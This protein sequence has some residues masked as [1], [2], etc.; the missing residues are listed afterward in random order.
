MPRCPGGVICPATVPQQQPPSSMPLLAC[1]N[2]AMGTPQVGFF[3]RVEPPTVL[4]IICLVSI[5]VSAFYFE[6]PD[7]MSYSPVGAQP[8]GFALLQPFGVYPWHAHVQPGDGHWSMPG[9]HRVAVPS[10]TLS[11]WEPSATQSPVPQPFHLYDGAYSLGGLVESHPIP[12]P[13][14]HGGEGSSFL[15]L[16]PSDD[17]V[18]S[19]LLYN[20]LEV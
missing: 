2:Y 18:D 4:Y 6:V 19:E 3:F 12:Q 10:A 15:G 5:L 7:W 16:V 8:L 20:T 14:L 9:M 1:A 11:R 13:S 17:M